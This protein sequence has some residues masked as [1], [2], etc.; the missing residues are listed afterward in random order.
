[1]DEGD[2]EKIRAIRLE[3]LQALPEI[4]ALC[5]RAF[6][7]NLQNQDA[8][9]QLLSGMAAADGLFD[10]AN[11]LNGGSESGFK[12]SSCGWH[13]EFLRFDDRVAI[14]ADEHA[15][16]VPYTQAAG[17]DRELKDFKKGAPTSSDGFLSPI[18]ESDKGFDNRSK[19]LLDMANRAPSPEPALLLRNFLGSFVCSKCGEKGPIQSL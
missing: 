15:P 19:E 8:V 2:L 1:V 10:L 11:L 7:E 12:C 16:G 3:F 14:Y 18:K 9:T 17:E 5:Q 13:F 4:R 6:Q